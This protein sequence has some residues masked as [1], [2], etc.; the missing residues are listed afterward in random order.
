MNNNNK[1]LIAGA[2][3]FSLFG[4]STFASAEWLKEDKADTFEEALKEGQLGLDFRM[5]YE[6]VSDGDQGAQALTL[7]SR[8]S[9]RTQPY[10][11]VHAF[12]EFDDVRAIPNDRN[13]FS[14]ANGQIDDLFVEDPEG[15]EVNQAWLAYDVANTLMKFGRQEVRLNNE[16]ILGADDWRQNSQTFSAF[17]VQNESLNYTR[18]SFVQLNDV[19]TNSDAS[20]DF[21]HQELNAKLFDLNYRGFWLSDLSFYALWISDHPDDAQWETSTYGVNF[22]GKLGGEFTIDYQLDIAR[23]EDA[24]SNP[25]SYAV[26]YALLDLVFAYDAYRVK[27]GYERLGAENQGYFVSPLGSL[28]NFQ[29]VSDQF[30]NNGLGNIASG[31]KDRYLGLGYQR[32]LSMCKSSLPLDLSITYHHYDAEN[33]TNGLRHL[34]EEWVMAA[35]ISSETMRTEIQFAEYHAGQYGNDDRHIWLT[36]GVGI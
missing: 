18:F 16:R 19:Q 26:N 34:G 24:G 3:S 6:D 15:T 12:I 13:Y 35:G 17:S 20:L 14:G 27:T 23:Q 22:K 5:R 10:N 32:S 7:R 29:G 9:Y 11:F 33:Q 30:F 36:L 2:L 28:H 31:I 21:A 1:R 8:L 4:L 25:S